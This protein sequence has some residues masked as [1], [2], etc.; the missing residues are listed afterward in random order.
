M[1]HNLNTSTTPFLGYPVFSTITVILIILKL[2]GAIEMGWGWILLLQIYGPIVKWTVMIVMILL[3]GGVLALSM[4]IGS[5][6]KF[7]RKKLS[8]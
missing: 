1:N 3:A 5:G 2:N 6:F 7:L 4:V 8:S